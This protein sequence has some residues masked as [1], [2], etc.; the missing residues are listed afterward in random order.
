MNLFAKPYVKLFGRDVIET[1][2]CM[3]EEFAEDCFMLLTAET[4]IKANPELLEIQR[5][6]K[7]HLGE[8][9]FCRLDEIP[10]F[11][12][13]E[14]LRA[15]R[16]R[17]STEGYRSPDLSGY[18]KDSGTKKDEGLIAVVNDDGTI[19]TYKVEPK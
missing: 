3:I 12:T 19:T 4:P 18:L 8:N 7:I 11:L 17:P 2:P 16:D 1:V 13:M 15:G 5:R 14:D 9:A 6:V 10:T